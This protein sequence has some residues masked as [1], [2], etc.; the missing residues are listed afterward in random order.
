VVTGQQVGLF[1]GPLYTIYKALTTIK[2]AAN[3]KQAKAIPVFYLVS[4]DHDFEEVRW[5]GIIDKSNRFKRLVYHDGDQ[6]YRKPVSDIVIR[7]SIKN[8]LDDLDHATP[9]TEFKDKILSDVRSFYQQGTRFSDAF[10]QLFSQIFKEYGVVLLDSSDPELKPLI[11]NVFEKELKDQVTVQQILKTNKILK[12]KGYHKQLSVQ[13]NRPGLFVLENGRHS[14]EKTSH[15]YKNLH[16]GKQYTIEELLVRPE[17]LSPKAALRPIVQDTLLPTIAYVAGPGEIAYWAQ[18][19]HVYTG[20]SLNM[21][22]VVPR[23]G[24]TLIEPKI[25]KHLERYQLDYEEI[26]EKPSNLVDEK[27]KTLIPSDIM[28]KIK[29]LE[30]MTGENSEKLFDDIIAIEPTME[31]VIQKV[32][33]NIQNQLQLL[34]NKVSNAIGKRQRIIMRQLNG[35]METIFPDKML[36]ERQLNILPFLI[37]YSDTILEEIYESIDFKGS[38]HKILEL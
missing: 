12:E 1:T 20:F 6:L 36:Q 10:A 13:P 31:K 3:M 24:F 21:P 22:I 28:T 7:P 33:N 9:S 19:K 11:T 15:G 27:L 8:V 17:L 5:A 4:E 14:I 23:A 26:F 35:I 16:S 37:K 38:N 32:Q 2:L 30:I 25:K 29:K 34:E 18:L